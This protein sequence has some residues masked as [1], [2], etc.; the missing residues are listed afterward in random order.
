MIRFLYKINNSIN[1]TQFFLFACLLIV[2]GCSRVW[3]LYEPATDEFYLNQ[4]LLNQVE[5]TEK[6]IPIK[7]NVAVLS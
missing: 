3:A 6:N 7:R 1:I 4:P 2:M 5:F